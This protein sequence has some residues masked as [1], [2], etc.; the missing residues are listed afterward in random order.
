ML[1]CCGTELSGSP[2]PLDPEQCEMPISTQLP[3][4]TVDILVLE[5]IAL[6]CPDSQDH[7]RW[8]S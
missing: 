6:L 3:S 4:L 1:L 5:V 7:D 2:K 8:I